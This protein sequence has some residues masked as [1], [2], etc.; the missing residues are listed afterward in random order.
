MK[1]N[2]FKR[3][4]LP[5]AFI[6]F[7]YTQAQTVSGTVSDENGPLPGANVLVKGTTN[8][9]QTDF[10]GNYELSDVPNDA[11]LVFSFISFK[12][13]EVPV[14]G[15]STINAILQSDTQALDEVVVIGYGTQRKSDLTGS[16]STISSESIQ[17]MPTTNPE[18]AL[19]GKAAGVNVSSNS[20]RP[21]GNTNVRIRGN[22]SINANNS[23]LYVVDGV[24][25]AGPINYLNPN[26]IKSMEVLKDASATAIYGAR[27]ANG[28]II[29]TT[30]RGSKTGGQVSFDSFISIGEMVRKLDVLNSEEFLQVEM[31]SYN[32]AQKYDPVGW[33]NGKYENPMNYR[34]DRTLFDA[35]GNP[36]YDTDWQEEATRTAITQNHNLSFTGGDEKTSY[37]LYL[38]HSDQEGVLLESYLKRYSGRLVLDGQVKDWLKVGGSFTF[39][40]IEENRVDGG[41]GGLTALRMMVET[42]PIVPV[43]YPSGDYGTNADYPNM[44][45]GENPVNILLNRT[46]ILKTQ[47]FLG[48]VYANI[49]IA[50][51]LQLRTSIGANINNT[52][53]NFYSGRELNNLSANFQG[54]ATIRNTRTNYW[55]FENFLT[56]DYEINENH[57]IN[58]MGGLS[59]QQYDYFYSFAGSRGFTDDFYQYNNLEVGANPLTP[60]SDVY[61]W[62]LNSFFGRVNYSLMNKYLFTITGRLDGSSKFGEDN[63]RAFFPSAAFA[64][65]VSEEDFLKDSETIS[66]LKFRTSYGETGNSEIGV[67]QSLASLGSSTAILG[68]ERF[69]GVGIGTLANPDLKWEKTAQFD[70][71]IELGMFNNRIE[72]ETDVYYKKTTD[73]LL[74]APV[75][76][77]SGYSN[78]YSNIGSMENKGLELTLNTVNIRSEDF[79]WT[80][81][82]NISFNKNEILALGEQDDDIFPGPGFLSD[83]NILRVGESVGSFYGLVREGTWGSDEAAEAAVYGLLPGDIKHADLNDDGQINA[84]DRKI[85]GSG[86]PEGFGALFNTFTYKNIDLTVD[87]QFS[88]GNDVLNLSRH[89]GEDRTGQ[90]NSY[91]TV[92]DGWT[93]D[94]QNTMIAQNR[95]SSAYY[96]STIDSRMVE[97]ASFI[98][99][100]NLILGYNFSQD[101]LDKFKLKRL[102]L[103]ASVQNFFL[104]TDYTGYDP[105]VS[106]YGDAFAQGI[107]FFDYPKPRTFTLGVNLTF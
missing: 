102:R 77:S 106:T 11:V 21:G 8:G 105:E 62:T 97:D 99:G 67:Y 24:I 43:K 86:Y 104:A 48:D 35:N 79:S 12:T 51:N 66:N 68:G 15:Q 74:N 45:G 63:K 30:K 57:R 78:I 59:W 7:G 38:N 3:L 27:G 103:Y 52:Q 64:W 107:T 50:K 73:M 72:L 91:A 61:Q 42:L 56:Y 93:P 100:R 32:N 33:A 80:T 76:T 82:F 96:R 10:D 89:S 29:V 26:D 19:A 87:L 53:D 2:L 1:T 92:L 65:K 22:N 44:E 36:L 88:Y 47:T 41:V 13:K 46:N 31:N 90:A 28:V 71:G 54:E 4:V 17:E 75:P 55:Q 9:T 84:A 14:G 98:R 60:D 40:H 58:A 18:Q 70:A 34:N 5:I 85:I 83:T 37:G 94:N 20:G 25:G 101:V 49:D 39:N 69:P 23:P 81:T 16:V 6:C 95:P